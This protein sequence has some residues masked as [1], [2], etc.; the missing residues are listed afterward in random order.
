M[1]QRRGS[2]RRPA[3][4]DQWVGTLTSP[5]CLGV[6]PCPSEK[7]TRTL[8]RM[9]VTV[10]FKSYSWSEDLRHTFGGGY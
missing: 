4:D 1:S 8:G 6:E 3:P 2:V 10:L 5:W 9:L 7:V